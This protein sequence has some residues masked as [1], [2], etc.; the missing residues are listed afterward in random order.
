VLRA[1]SLERRDVMARNSRGFFTGE[2]VVKGGGIKVPSDG[3]ISA[4]QFEDARRIAK[5]AGQDP[6]KAIEIA[7]S[8]GKGWLARLFGG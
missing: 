1:Y 8:E 7:R 2:A 4:R 5:A 6:S 3:F